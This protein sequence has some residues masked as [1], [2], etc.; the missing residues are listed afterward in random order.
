MNEICKR[1]WDRDLTGKKWAE[2][3][4]FSPRTVQAVL[5]GKRGSWICGKS[6]KIM[7]ALIDQGLMTAK[8][9]QARDTRRNNVA[10]KNKKR[11]VKV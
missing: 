6:K 1:I 2:N 11:R 10:S 3:N 7:L 4:G 8:E 5:I 9:M